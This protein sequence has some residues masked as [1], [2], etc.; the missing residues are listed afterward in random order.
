MGELL[1]SGFSY[2][3][4]HLPEDW[5]LSENM[6]DYVSLGNNKS[7][8]PTKRHYFVPNHEDEERFFLFSSEWSTKFEFIYLYNNDLDTSNS[9]SV[10]HFL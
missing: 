10:S 9:S 8:F 6:S 2:Q 1:Q 3:N 7:N 5:L 4:A